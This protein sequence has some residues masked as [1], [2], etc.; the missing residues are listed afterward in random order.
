MCVGVPG[1]VLTVYEDSVE[2]ET[3]GQVRKVA[4]LTVPDLGEGEHVLVSGGMVIKRV[5]PEEASGRRELFDQLLRLLEEENRQS[6]DFPPTAS[7]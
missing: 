4:N 7:D 5:P 2:V 3:A 6:E 1:K